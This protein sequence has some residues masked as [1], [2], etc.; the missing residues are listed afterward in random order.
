VTLQPEAALVSAAVSVLHSSEVTS[1]LAAAEAAFLSKPVK[2]PV[3]ASV[4]VSSMALRL[5]QEEWRSP[6]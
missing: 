2:L 5:Q 1:Q 3:R 6:V 4:Q